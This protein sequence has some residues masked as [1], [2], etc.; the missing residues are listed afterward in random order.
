[1]I[2]AGFFPFSFVCFSYYWI[3]RRGHKSNDRSRSGSGTGNGRR[4]AL[5]PDLLYE[6]LPVSVNVATDPGNSISASLTFVRHDINKRN[7][8]VIYLSAL[9]IPL[10]LFAAKHA[11]NTL[12][13]AKGLCI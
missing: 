9:S 7:L 11:E 4:T 3:S 12:T 2:S 10:T 8:L 5:F 6:R 13:K 1:M